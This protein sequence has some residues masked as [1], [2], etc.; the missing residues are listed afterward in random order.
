MRQLRKYANLPTEERNLLL[1]A[2]F[3]VL[4]VR[5]GLWL[6][7]AR[8][9]LGAA[10]RREE[11][12]GRGARVFSVDRLSWAIRATARYVPSATCLTQAIALQWLLA[13]F[14][15]ASRVHIGVKK[16]RS[17]QLQA[18][19]WVECKKQVV[20]GGSEVRDYIPLVWWE[21]SARSAG[22]HQA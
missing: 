17:T 2:A 14:G 10:C 21:E 19:A 11:R 18:H 3:F 16:H 12:G 7:P 8:A 9:L 20:I 4:M 15:Y 5:L 6:L 13:R 22:E 1:R